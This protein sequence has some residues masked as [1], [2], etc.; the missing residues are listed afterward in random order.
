MLRRL[1]A[2]QGIKDA[3]L[4]QVFR[5]TLCS[6][7]GFVE[8]DKTWDFLHRP[9]RILGYDLSKIVCLEISRIQ[10]YEGVY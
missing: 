3:I 4:D 5:K 9:N 10:I 6:K 7:I 2:V 1:K 8:I